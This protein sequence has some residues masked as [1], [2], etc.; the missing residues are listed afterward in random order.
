MHFPV[1][2]GHIW[3]LNIRNV[4]SM[5]QEVNFDFKLILTCACDS[6]LLHWTAKLWVFLLSQYIKP[7]NNH[8]FRIM[9]Y[10][11]GIYQPFSP[12]SVFCKEHSIVPCR[13]SFNRAWVQ[14][15]AL[16]VSLL[17]FIL[18]YFFLQNNILTLRCKLRT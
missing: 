2:T 11:L 4:T 14:N 5:V 6:L 17:I 16:A 13:T 9:Y 1:A 8:M 7:H 3:P 12:I 18:F 10:C 15:Q